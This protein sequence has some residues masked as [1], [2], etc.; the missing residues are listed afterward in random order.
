M[1]NQVEDMRLEETSVGAVITLIIREMLHEADYAAFVPLIESQLE[2]GR[3]V[4]LLVI[5]HAFKGWS[6]GALW[7]DTK[8]AANHFQPIDRLAVVG[9]RQWEEGVVVFVKP[10]AAAEMRYF[11]ADDVD[12]ARRWVHAE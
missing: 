12:R 1:P 10:F 8:F 3:S 5:L 2:K 9:E 11:D 6:S 4:R 7:A